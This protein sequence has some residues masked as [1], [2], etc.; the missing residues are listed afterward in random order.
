MTDRTY[1]TELDEIEKFLKKILGEE[2]K[3]SKCYDD[4]LKDM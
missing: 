1:K 3:N 4:D 2:W